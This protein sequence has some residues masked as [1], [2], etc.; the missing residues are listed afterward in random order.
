[1]RLILARSVGIVVLLVGIGASV[2]WFVAEF[3]KREGD[4]ATA[5]SPPL[6]RCASELDLG[7]Q[8][9]RTVASGPTD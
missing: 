6:L 8:E 7:P 4:K 2:S 5:V 9:I 3:W 1:M